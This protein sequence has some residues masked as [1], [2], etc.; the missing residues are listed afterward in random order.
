MV[1]LPA[2]VMRLIN[3]LVN[4]NTLLQTLILNTCY[5]VEV[6]NLSKNANSVNLNI[7]FKK[8]YIYIYNL[9]GYS[10]YTFIIIHTLCKKSV[11]NIFRI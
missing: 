3:D 2:V 9:L 7:L 6:S 10:Q 8:K 1:K 11:K 4:L 5:K